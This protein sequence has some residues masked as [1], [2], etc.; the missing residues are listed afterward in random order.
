MPYGRVAHAGRA[1][2]MTVRIFVGHLNAHDMA[3]RR[4]HRVSLV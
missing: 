3:E 4:Q 2:D 1:L